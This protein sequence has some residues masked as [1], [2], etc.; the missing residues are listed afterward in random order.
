MTGVAPTEESKSTPV[1]IKRTVYGSY[2]CLSAFIRIHLRLKNFF[3][4]SPPYIRPGNH[5]AIAGNAIKIAS[6]R[7]SVTTNGITP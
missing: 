7:M 3:L 6:R 2:F 4:E 1:R 5:N